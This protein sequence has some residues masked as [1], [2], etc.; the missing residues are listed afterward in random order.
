MVMSL[1]TWYAS[2]V[3]MAVF[4]KEQLLLRVEMGTSGVMTNEY[5]GLH[6]QKMATEHKYVRKVMAVITRNLNW[7]QKVGICET[8]SRKGIYWYLKFTFIRPYSLYSKIKQSRYRPGVGSRKLRFP[9][10]MT[11]GQDGGKVVSLT[12]RPSLP[13]GNNPGTH[14][15]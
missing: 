8:R 10:Y 13:P 15:Y 9:D 4:V 5:P 14:F 11:T 7:S 2:C 1:V 12:H 6:S 3:C